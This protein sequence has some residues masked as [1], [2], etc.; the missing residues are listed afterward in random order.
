MKKKPEGNVGLS[1]GGSGGARS[2]PA[3]RV[4]VLHIDDD[5]NDTELLQAASRQ[6]G[7]PFVLQHIHDGEQAIAYLGGTGP[8]ADRRR[9]PMPA[10]ILLDL[11]LP[12]TSGFEVLR[13]MRSHPELASVPIVVLSG[14]ES[15]D[16]IQLTYSMGA[17]SYIVK[18][19]GFQ[20]LI[21][22]VETLHSVW[23]ARPVRTPGPVPALPAGAPA[24]GLDTDFA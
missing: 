9:F 17:N 14:S 1:R 10:L 5:P 11:K 12:R 2:L 22:V 23:L 19:L 4:T 21:K 24:A 18:P 16:H 20:E 13:W 7:A 3:Q 8:Y 6:A 15:Q